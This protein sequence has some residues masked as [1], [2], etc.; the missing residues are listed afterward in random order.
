[1]TLGPVTHYRGLLTLGDELERRAGT[2]RKLHF[3]RLVSY[4]WLEAE[5]LPDKGWVEAYVDITKRWI[6]QFVCML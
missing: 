6:L 2:L 3:F 4:P 5:L 1:M